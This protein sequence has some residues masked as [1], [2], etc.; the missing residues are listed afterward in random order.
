MQWLSPCLDRLPHSSLFAGYPCD[1]RKQIPLF[2]FT[3]AALR[4][5]SSGI[6]S[7]SPHF[8]LNGGIQ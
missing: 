5:P 8:Q 4:F 2:R 6:G 7:G 3:G 1:E